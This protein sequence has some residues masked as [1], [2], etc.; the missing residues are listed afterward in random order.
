MCPSTPVTVTVC[1]TFQFAAVKMSEEVDR[2]PAA[3]SEI[4]R[5]SCRVGV[6]MVVGTVVTVAEPPVSLVTRPAGG[7]TAMAAVSSCRLLPATS[8]GVRPLYL[9]SALVAAPVTI[10]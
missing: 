6:G 3:G 5:A 10:V 9:L 4:G 7:D 1:G 8:A 2:L